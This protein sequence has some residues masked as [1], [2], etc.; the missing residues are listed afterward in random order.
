MPVMSTR[1]P[2]GSSVRSFAVY[3]SVILSGV[4]LNGFQ[5]QNPWRHRTSQH[6]PVSA[7]LNWRTKKGTINKCRITSRADLGFLAERFPQ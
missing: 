5:I 6:T 3:V 4:T 7:I 2:P 1:D